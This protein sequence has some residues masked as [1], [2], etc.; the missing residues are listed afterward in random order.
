MQSFQDLAALRTR[1]TNALMQERGP[2]GN[3]QAVRRMS[4]LLDGVHDSMADTASRP[5]VPAPAAPAPSVPTTAPNVGSDVFT[6]SGQR[7]GVQYQVADAPSLVT[8][9]NADMTANP[10]YPAEMQPRARDRAASEVQVANIASRLTPERLGASS[11]V[12]DGAPIVGPDGIVESG[13]G[14][15]MAL[16]RAYDA[17]G[18]QAQS[19]RDWLAGQGHDTTGMQQPV[20]IRRRVT[21][22][23]PA[24]RVAFAD[25]GNAPTTLS[26]SATERAAGDARR[27]PDEA[28]DQVQ[29]G[30]VTSAENRSFVRSFLQHAVEPGQEGAFVTGDGQLSQ[31]GAAR[32]RAA[33]VH[34]AY[35]SDGLSAALAETTDGHAAVLANAMRDS[36]G[37]M[38]RL[39][40]GI[41]AGHV[42]PAVDL[43]PHLVEA[44]QTV[45]QARARGVS[46]ADQV[47]QRDMLG[48]GV[49]PQAERLLREAYGPEMSGRMSRA[50][51]SDMLATYAR[52]AGEQS[53]A[54]NLFGVNLTRDELL[55]GATARYGQTAETGGRT[56]GRSTTGPAGAGAGA[57]GDQARG[58]VPGAQRETA[59]SGGGSQGGQA[60]R[61]L[62]QPA[63][64]LTPNFDQAAADR[65]QA[66][67]S[68]HA[69]RK[70]TYGSRAP[71]VGPVLASGPTAGSF[72]MP[73]SAVPAAIF[74]RAPGAAER[75]QSAVR[76]GLS[77][78]QIADYAAFDLRRT[79]TNKDGVL[80]PA[81]FN[82]WRQQ[83][84]EAF[85]ALTQA[86]PAI[87]GKFDTAQQ[88]SARLADLQTQRAALD[89]THPLKPGWGDAEVMQRVWQPG[90]KGA[91]SVRSVASAARGSPVAA[92]SIADY[93]AYSLRKMAAP[94]G[95]IDPAKYA[96]WA[97]TYD[98][99]LSARPDIKAQ[100]DSVAK[101]QEALNTS[102]EQHAQ[103]LKDFQAGAAKHFLGNA[104]PADQ[105][106]RI[107]NSTTRQRDMADLARLTQNDPAARAG[108]QAAIRDH[109]FA[110]LQGN[111]LG[112]QT[113][114]AKLKS[115]QF[116]TFIK[117][118]LPAMREVMTP[119]QVD[120]LDRVAQTLQ[121]DNLS[122]DGT[123]VQGG[124]DTAQ[125]AAMASNSVGSTLL[126][127]ARA[128]GLTGILTLL[129]TKM[130]PAGAFVGNRVGTAMAGLRARGI[131]QTDDLIKEAMLNPALGRVLLSN[132]TDKSAPHVASALA[133]IL[134]QMTATR[135]AHAAVAVQHI[136]SPPQNA[137]AGAGR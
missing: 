132:V 136:V 116:Q 6:P 89:A 19:Y 15:V 108:I 128:H 33:L 99:A 24:E 120:I 39:K 22:L 37:P 18:P 75:V 106:G 66:M 101:A 41:E 12:A 86:D 27:L 65:Y 104:D 64:A 35:G 71:G 55:E 1:L 82:K 105:V 23:S 69:E 52:R 53:T 9:H 20:L 117:R 123:R 42:D 5:D 119:T 81:A 124:S 84:G 29:P 97:K 61:I 30:D 44:A 13:N 95:V 96:A 68:A 14:R 109:I 93:A 70:D 127:M 59:P 76:A 16:R 8:S 87:R 72:K 102:A 114:V 47:A 21:D 80:D 103:A 137:L 32:V 107:L 88:A 73:D 28:L 118:S 63:S 7:I 121:R 56:G 125:K 40:A 129:G 51:F 112:G 43:A 17:N 26:M 100:F 31:E 133:T 49:S 111:A 110:K 3:P 2:T 98:G 74:S 115:D 113:G 126:S 94:D 92:S 45:A 122:V 38:A 34:R 91:D 131:I 48:G 67:R 60:G 46:L 11:T 10:A 58:S 135:S 36:A 90:A 54:G 79:A 77:P 50:Q 83:N 130:G 62:E 78:S 25:S 134:G 57:Y 85:Q 4:T